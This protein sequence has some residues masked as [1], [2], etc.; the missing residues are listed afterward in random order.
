KIIISFF[1]HNS[2]IFSL[3]VV[4]TLFRYN[5][6]LSCSEMLS[7]VKTNKITIWRTL[8]NYQHLL[9]LMSKKDLTTRIWVSELI[10]RQK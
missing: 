3:D 6:A 10:H 8:K 9:Y 1:A 7:T 2:K 5:H 4:N